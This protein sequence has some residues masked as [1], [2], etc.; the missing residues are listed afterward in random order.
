MRKKVKNSLVYLVIIGMFVNMISFNHEIVLADYETERISIQEVAEL[1]CI[2]KASTDTE[3]WIVNDENDIEYPIDSDSNE[4]GNFT[5]HVD[6]INACTVPE[7]ILKTASTEEL[8]S[9]IQNYPLLCDIFA[10]NSIEEGLIALIKQS[11]VFE[12]LFTREDIAD[13]LYDIYLDTEISNNISESEEAF[14]MVADTVLL[15]A[16]LAQDYILDKFSSEKK[17]NLVNEVILKS[18]EKVK[19]DIYNG[20]EITFF[21]VAEET[22]SINELNVDYNVIDLT[23]LNNNEET[24]IL[25]TATT[26]SSTSSS[27]TTVKTPNGTKVTVIIYS[28]NGDT[29]A[30]TLTNTMSAKYPSATVVRNADNRYNCHS[31]AWYSTSTS[32]YYW[33]NSPKKYVSDGSYKL[34]GSSPTANSQKI[35]YKD[36]SYVPLDDWIHSG[37]VVSYKSSS[38]YKVQSKWGQGP[39]MRH[40]K[41]YSPYTGSYTTISFYKKAS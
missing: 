30:N 18:E 35:V 21:D 15:E 34:A 14:Y 13:K 27:T 24:S 23:E 1:S 26:V 39:L 4:W 33:M 11:N 41:G 28:Y 16:L 38:S 29:W 6:M 3:D 25:T 5:S 20:N 17:D 8:I 37:I 7:D 9:L 19:L 10:Y 31:Y 22:E 36:Q 2:Y 12:E 32:N 40:S